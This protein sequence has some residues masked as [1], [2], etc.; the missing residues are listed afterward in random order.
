MRVPLV[1]SM[2]R[3]ISATTFGLVAGGVGSHLDSM[4]VDNT[5]M[6]YDGNEGKRMAVE[7][8]DP[9]TPSMRRWCGLL[10][11][12]MLILLVLCHI[13]SCIQS[14]MLV[15]LCPRGLMLVLQEDTLVSPLGQG[16]GIL[17]FCIILPICS[18]FQ[19]LFSPLERGHDI[20]WLSARTIRRKWQPGWAPPV[21]LA[22][23]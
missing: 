3:G 11:C 7:L 8:M 22:K 13:S 1:K 5:P 20:Y 10:V 21:R 14:I 23:L 15:C 12:Q 4:Q 17:N 9:V 19:T 18:H 16:V 2:G 6:N